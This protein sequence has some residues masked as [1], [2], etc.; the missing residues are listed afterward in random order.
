MR[1]SSEVTR[2]TVVTLIGSHSADWY[3]L[4]HFLKPVSSTY[5][6]QEDST[7]PASKPQ[8]PTRPIISFITLSCA[9]IFRP[10]LTFL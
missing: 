2:A 5:R 6:S 3:C 9:V 7:V 1:S 10:Y 8:I 4:Q